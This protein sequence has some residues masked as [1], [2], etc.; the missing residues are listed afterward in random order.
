MDQC[1]P[2]SAE[3]LARSREPSPLSVTR[4]P[5]PARLSLLDNP[6]HRLGLVGTQLLQRSAHRGP[7]RA[8]AGVPLGAGGNAGSQASHGPGG[9]V[10][11]E[12]AGLSGRFPRVG[13]SASESMVLGWRVEGLS[14][15]L[16]YGGERRGRSKACSWPVVKP[17]AGLASGRC[18][19]LSQDT[20][21]QAGR[22]PVGNHPESSMPQALAL[23]QN[24]C[25]GGL[26]VW[27]ERIKGVSCFCPS[28]S[29]KQDLRRGFLFEV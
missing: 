20:E 8:A 29:A 25:P 13:R 24:R 23:T 5:P 18:P 14:C 22:G 12:Q 9:W 26:V 1:L 3:V 27:M 21:P 6:E 7:L 16:S 19:S 10:E 2:H 15:L 4:R 28:F 11:A 17:G